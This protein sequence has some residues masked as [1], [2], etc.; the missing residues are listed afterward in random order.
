MLTL[1][2]LLSLFPPL[3]SSV[4]AAAACAGARQ[5][6][7]G[8]LYGSSYDYPINTNYPQAGCGLPDPRTLA[9]PGFGVYDAMTTDYYAPSIGQV[10]QSLSA[11][12]QI[13]K[14]EIRFYNS[15]SKVHERSSAVQVVHNIAIGEGLFTMILPAGWSKSSAMP[16]LLSSQPGDWSNNRGLFDQSLPRIAEIA[17]ASKAL[18]TPVLAILSN[19]GGRQSQGLSPGTLRAVSDA[20]DYAQ[21]RYGADKHRV[22]T[23]GFS[24]GGNNA[25]LWATNPLQRDY[26]VIGVFAEAGPF[27]MG[28]ILSSPFTTFSPLG[29]DLSQLFGNPSA[30]QYGQTPGPQD[31]QRYALNLMAGASTASQADGV[32]AYSYLGNLA[33]TQPYIAL[34]LPTHDGKVPFPTGLAT[35]TRLTQLGIPHLTDIQLRGGHDRSLLVKNALGDFL[36]QEIF[37]KAPQPASFCTQLRPLLQGRYFTARPRTRVGSEPPVNPFVPVSIKDLPFLAIFPK[38]MPV[39]SP[40]ELVLCGKQGSSYMI[41][42]TDKA[43]GKIYNT[44]GDLVQSEC[45]RLVFTAPAVSTTLL[46][47]FAYN[48]QI[49]DPTKVNAVD[50]AGNSMPMETQITAGTSPMSLY[51]VNPSEPAMAFGLVQGMD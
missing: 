2:F 38:T 28:Q 23:Y 42:I 1:V 12:E 26:R 15:P 35:D 8:S 10:Q 44:A 22:V 14:A 43:T 7:P 29:I 37:C 20:L 41:Q 17:A 16:I 30:F 34:G 39:A 5:F 11:L 40:G 51:L 45:S 33:A 19:A 21:A 24:R 32:S 9:S 18:G 31:V 6:L 47:R 4:E 48:L 3:L 13:A 49:V 46:W 36:M 50:S 25:L 27:Q